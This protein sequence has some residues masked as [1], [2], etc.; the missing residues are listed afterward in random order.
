MDEAALK[1]S[2][3]LR[4]SAGLHRTLEAMHRERGGDP[5]SVKAADDLRALQARLE[6]HALRVELLHGLMPGIPQPK[7]SRATRRA[8]GARRMKLF[9]EAVALELGLSPADVLAVAL[10]EMAERAERDL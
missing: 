1:Y 4:A 10:R 2:Q 8:E 3:D 6:E 7:L 5:L 9:L